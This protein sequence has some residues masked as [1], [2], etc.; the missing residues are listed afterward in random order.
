LITANAGK[1]PYPVISL[2]HH[3]RC[4]ELRL[5]WQNNLYRIVE[6]KYLQSVDRFI[7]NSQ[8]TRSMIHGLTIN[9]KPSIVAYPPMDGFGEVI[10]E[11]QI[12]KR[13]NSSE[14]RIL[15]PGNVIERCEKAVDTASTFGCDDETARNVIKGFNQTKRNSDS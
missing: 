5:K 10:P 7:L 4:S 8:T 3:L 14:L 13:A 11:D 6:K 15:F 12:I 1:H 2:V 9:E